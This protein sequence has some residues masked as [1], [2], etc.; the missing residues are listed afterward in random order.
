MTVLVSG[1]SGHIGANLVRALLGA[2][3]KVRCLIHVHCQAIDGLDVETIEGD[4]LDPASLDRAM[5]GIET[6]YHL[7]ARISLSMNNEEPVWAVNVDGTRNVVEACL[8]NK[9]SRLVHFGSIH[10][11]V[12]EPFD[13]PVDED[14]PLAIDRRYSPYDRSKAAGVLEVKK[15]IERGLDAVIIYPTGAFGPY[16]YEPSFFGQAL[17]NIASRKLPA[18][19]TG[20]FDWV[21]ARDVA[22]GAMLAETRAACGNTYL[23]SGHW[24]SVPKIDAMI[25]ELTGGKTCR[26]TVPL[27]LASTGAPFIEAWSRYSRTRPI[28]TK[29]SLSALRSN[30]SISH[31]R[32]AA[33]LGYQ[34]RPFRETLADTLA[35][36]TENGALNCEIYPRTGRTE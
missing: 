8:R 7:A 3:R 2:G 33:D 16:D 34:P 23:L 18:L 9:V 25:A 29:F 14:R 13:V 17:I 28:Y 31:A 24:V 12:Q 27:W 32:A 30:R 20:G 21:D 36:F 22:A 11:L 35:W 19:V 5:D 1:A 10:A 15:G 4:V 6:V 26:L